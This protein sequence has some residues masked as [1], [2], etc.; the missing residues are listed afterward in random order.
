M[1]TEFMHDEMNKCIARPTDDQTRYWQIIVTAHQ[2]SPKQ[3]SLSPDEEIKRLRDNSATDKSANRIKV[4]SPPK[5]G[6][7]KARAKKGPASSLFHP[8]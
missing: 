3:F 5:L 2:P 1:T 4:F 8:L 7:T 6:I